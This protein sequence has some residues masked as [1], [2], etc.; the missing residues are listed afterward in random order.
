MN[1]AGFSFFERDVLEVAPDLIG[2]IIVRK[3]P[4]GTIL[5]ARITETEAYRGTDD[6]ACH[7]HKGKTPRNEVMFAAGGHIYVYLIYG[8][9]WMLNFVTG[10]E[11]QPEAVLIRGIEGFDGPGKL[12]K[13]LKINKE[14]YGENLANSE[15]IWIE[16]DGNH[17]EHYTTARI[18]IDYAGEYWKNV[19]WRFVMKTDK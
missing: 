3:L 13:F 19:L 12:S 5:Q 18:G 9:H 1:K 4:D 17:F 14:L 7:A 11:N 8:M 6:L 2:K 15:K 16:E 10:A